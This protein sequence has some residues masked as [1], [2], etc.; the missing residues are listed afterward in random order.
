M[1]KI[2]TKSEQDA[3]FLWGAVKLLNPDAYMYRGRGGMIQNGPTRG[4][5]TIGSYD[6]GVSYKMIRDWFPDRPFIYSTTHKET[7]WKK[8]ENI[9]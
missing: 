9:V 2:K 5:W 6:I 7:V 3:H 8:S 1:F 4:Y